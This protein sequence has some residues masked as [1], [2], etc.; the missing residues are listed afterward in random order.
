MHEAANARTRLAGDDE[1]LPLRG[2]R[3]PARGH[4][5][6]LV[7]VLELVAERHEPSVHLRPDARVADLAV[8]GIGEIDRRR[9]ARKLDELAPR[10]EAEDL[11]L[12]Q[13]ELGVIEEVVR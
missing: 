1:A 8:H 12:V 13:I 2:R 3:A 11:I 6:D 4:D 5:L 9:A 7:A 10:R